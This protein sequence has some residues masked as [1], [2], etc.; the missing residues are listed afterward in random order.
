M[1]KKQRQIIYRKAAE[2]IFNGIGD[3][4]C[5][6]QI[7][8]AAEILKIEYE[9]MLAKE[10]HFPEF[11]LFEPRNLSRR[12]WWEQGLIEPRLLALLFSAEICN[13]Q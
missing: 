9:F 6:G 12:L 4:Y 8:Q 5:C 3:S 1:T 13:D 2:N 7:Q 10:K 11:F